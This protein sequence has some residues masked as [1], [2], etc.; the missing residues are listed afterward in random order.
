MFFLRYYRLRYYLAFFLPRIG[1]ANTALLSECPGAERAKYAVLG[2]IN[3]GLTA[4]VGWLVYKL[5]FEYIYVYAWE[6]ILYPCVAASLALGILVA[7]CRVLSMRQLGSAGYIIGGFLLLPVVGLFGGV[8]FFLSMLGRTG[9]EV[10][11]YAAAG[12]SI[13]ALLAIV[14]LSIAWHSPVYDAMSLREAAPP[15]GEPEASP[16]SGR[17][18]TEGEYRDRADEAL[19]A[20]LQ[21]KF[22]RNPHDLDAARQL[23]A[24]RKRLAKYDSAAEVVD[25]LLS[26][27]PENIELIRERAELYRQKG[28]EQRYRSTLAQA[29]PLV[30]RA[31]F[32]QNLGKPIR[33]TSLEVADLEFFGDFAWAFQPQVSVLLGK[34]GYGKSHLLRAL[35]AMLQDDE[36]IVSKFF[37]GGGRRARMRVDI[38]RAGEPATTTRTRLVF[39]EFLRQGAVARDSRHAIHRQVRGQHRFGAR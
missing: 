33:L 1:G 38:D 29:D 18:R 7:A 26:D 2:A 22:G 19:E 36:E 37:A 25:A 31:A 20:M 12:L 32:E 28:D 15:R 8:V 10:L 6:R 17:Q 35:A 14:I 3:L 13:W 16:V 30:A 23:I 5:L 27:D 9:G 21:A 39:D 11:A 34:N 24:V 4:L